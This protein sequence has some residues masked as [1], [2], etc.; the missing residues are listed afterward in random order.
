MRYRL[1]VNCIDV[2]VSLIIW[3]WVLT[4]ITSSTNRNIT[5]YL[6]PR[7]IF[8]MLSFC[9]HNC[10][11]LILGRDIVSSYCLLELIVRYFSSIIFELGFINVGVVGEKIIKVEMWYRIWITI[12]PFQLTLEY[13]GI[14]GSNILWLTYD[15]SVMW[16]GVW[17]VNWF[18]AS[19]CMQYW[20]KFTLT[21]YSWVLSVY[22]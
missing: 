7:W 11:L 21:H 12:T 22:P 10:A 13:Q 4:Y 20:M 16:F 8:K 15:W 1:L 9:K 17:I 19:S 3:W 5:V 18:T 6:I 14:L 2:P